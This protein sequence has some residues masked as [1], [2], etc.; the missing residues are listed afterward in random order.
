MLRG[1]IR[2]AGDERGLSEPS[3][4]ETLAA[5]DTFEPEYLAAM[6]D[7]NAAGPAKELVRAMQQAGVDLTDK[8][9]VNA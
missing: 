4:V 7:L 8:R 9:A 1:W 5:V 3:I 6:R 2:F